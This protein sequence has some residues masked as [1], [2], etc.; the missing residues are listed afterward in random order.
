MIPKE[1][2]YKDRSE[3]LRGFLILIRKDNLIDDIEKK[4]ALIIGH[5]FGFEQK[6]CED[7]VNSILDNPYVSEA[8]P[9]FSNKIIAR[10]FISE[11][12]RILIQIHELQMNEI[13]WLRQTAE[14]NE[15][16]DEIDE[17]LSV[18]KEN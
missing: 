7:S 15:L 5:N 18:E 4:M 13:N 14:V 2:P 17:L 3:F 9:V 1:I 12:F 16:E 6:F 10:H 11:T 8:P